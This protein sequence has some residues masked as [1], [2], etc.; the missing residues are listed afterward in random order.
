MN[1]Q[2]QSLVI[3]IGIC[4]LLCSGCS[5][6]EHIYN[7][8]KIS[9]YNLKKT[10]VERN[11]TNVATGFE[12]LFKETLT[13]S[14]EQAELC[15]AFIS[16]IRYL[17]DGSGYFFVESHEAW[18]V[19]HATKP[20]LIGTHRMEVQDIFG[21]YY[22]KDMVSTVKYIGYGFVDYYFNNPATQ[23]VQKKLAFVKSIPSAE[24]FIGSGFYDYDVNRLYE[25]YEADLLQVESLTNTM[26][27]GIS[28]VF[29]NFLPDS[30]ERVDFCRK[31]ID[32][33][34]FF[35]NQ[36]GYFFI[37]DSR[38]HNVAHG[39]QKNLQGENLYDYQDS[40]GNYVIRELLKVVETNGSGYYTYYWNNP[41]TS[42]EEPKQ[43]YVTGIEGSDYFIGSGIYLQE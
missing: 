7:Y 15:Q 28:G 25:A 31:M 12:T 6:T 21:K 33:I 29:E 13:D 43:A 18:M 3:S 32:N 5:K 40:Q 20:E 14:A 11:T 37:Y 30:S 2:L 26:A 22:V 1:K 19:A 27:T 42:Q 16:P 9:D 41:V 35:D 10:L 17:E 23:Q 39:I 36:S 24:F 8:D 4:M 34:R 38:C